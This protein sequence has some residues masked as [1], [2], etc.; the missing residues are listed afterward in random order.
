V[1]RDPPAT[2]YPLAWTSDGPPF[3]R[4]EERPSRTSAGR[5]TM[6][7]ADRFL[8]HTVDNQATPLADYDAFAT[9]PALQA[10]LE[11]E[12]GGWGRAQVAAFGPVAGG[13]LMRLGEEANIHRPVFKP[14]DRYGHRI[15]RVD[16]HPSWHR[17]M[18]L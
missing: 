7:I 12:G 18:Q 10:A 15:D 1:G 16:F 14:F 2:P 5:T 4:P 8:T 3:R 13:E 9:D 6:R 17:I 11:R